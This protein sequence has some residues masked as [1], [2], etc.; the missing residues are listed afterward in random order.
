[1]MITRAI[2]CSLAALIITAFS[3]ASLA[4][5]EAQ[6]RRGF[7]IQMPAASR[8]IV[9]AEGVDPK[10]WAH[11]YGLQHYQVESL[12]NKGS[13]LNLAMEE[14][15][16]LRRMPSLCNANGVQSCETTQCQQ[17]QLGGR[18]RSGP[19]IQSFRPRL[20]LVKKAPDVAQLLHPAGGGDAY[21]RADNASDFKLETAVLSRPPNAANYQLS[22]DQLPADTQCWDLVVESS[23]SK[24]VVPLESLVPA[25][26]IKRVLV[27]LPASGAGSARTGG[28]GSP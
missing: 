2:L 19:G 5:A 17:I 24:S 22:P 12:G 20:R 26:D 27:L 21:C 13:I 23:C 8:S 3:G 11:R 15:E 10:R 25:R 28:S 16:W 6:W 4:D 1:M 14:R 9:L 7:N 18:V